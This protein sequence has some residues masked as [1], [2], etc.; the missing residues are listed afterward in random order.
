MAQ[1]KQNI[2]RLQLAPWQ[3]QSLIRCD[4]PLSPDKN[5]PPRSKTGKG[6]FHLLCGGQLLTEGQSP[7]CL[8]DDHQSL[9]WKIIT[10]YS[11]ILED[12]GTKENAVRGSTG[13][14]LTQLA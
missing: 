9:H 7:F 2:P 13:L 3:G 12:C 1:K 10:W 5:N 14:G 4:F 11:H 6:K 8:C